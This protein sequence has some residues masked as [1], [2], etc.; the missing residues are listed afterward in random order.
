MLPLYEGILYGP[1][2]SRRIG[3]SLGINILPRRQKVCT[4]NCSYCQYGWTHNSPGG[5]TSAAD[6]WPTPD[7]IARSVAAALTRLAARGDRP[8]RLSLGGHGEPTLHPQ[9]RDVIAAVREVRDELAP[10]V[11]L[12]MLSNSSTLNSEAV[13]A[14]VMQLDERHFKLDA[15][16]TALM[17][18]LNGTTTSVEHIVEALRQVRPVVIHAIFVRDGQGRI[19]NSGDVAVSVWIGTVASVPAEKVQVYTLEHPPAW[20]YLQPVS[21]ARLEEIARLARLAGLTA[22]AFAPPAAPT[23]RA[24]GRRS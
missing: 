20:P 23:S 2:H 6:S 21:A 3:H 5:A 15:G 22:Q 14:A 24:A 11:P 13:R 10:G 16:D 7:V 8:A 18:L 9:L 12:A 19:D 4:F 1:T 17:R